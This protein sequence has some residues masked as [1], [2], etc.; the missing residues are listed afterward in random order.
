MI[1]EKAV[2][3]QNDIKEKTGLPSAARYSRYP[4]AEPHPPNGGLPENHVLTLPAAMNV[5]R[6]TISSLKTNSQ[7]KLNMSGPNYL[8][9]REQCITHA[10]L[11]S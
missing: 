10:V 7:R 9:G 4:D 11:S 5:S 8:T 2:H 3:R 1:S 6:V